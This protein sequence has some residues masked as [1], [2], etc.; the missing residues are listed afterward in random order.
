MIVIFL[1]GAQGKGSQSPKH[2][3]KQKPCAHS[4]HQKQKTKLCGRCP[5]TNFAFGVGVEF[6]VE[7]RIGHP[8]SATE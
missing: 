4:A 5:H 3:Q 2:K 7:F 1:G 8:S 6:E